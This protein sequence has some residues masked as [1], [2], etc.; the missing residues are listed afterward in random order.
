MV[1]AGLVLGT[2]LVSGLFWYRYFYRRE[3]AL[4][5]RLQKMIGQAEK[6]T[7]LRED[8]SEER[9]LCWRTV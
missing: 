3:R 9:C 6:G 2:A 5:D 1:Y 7:L 8:I 4:L